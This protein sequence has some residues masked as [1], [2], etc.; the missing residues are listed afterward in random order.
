MVKIGFRDFLYKDNSEEEDYHAVWEY[1]VKCLAPKHLVPLLNTARVLNIEVYTPLFSESFLSF[2][3]ILPYTERIGRK[4]EEQLALKYL[5]KS[6]V[7]R[8]SIGFDVAL[9]T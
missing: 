8:E 4:I 6:V 9:E 3:R 1:F 2:M 7:E 5:P